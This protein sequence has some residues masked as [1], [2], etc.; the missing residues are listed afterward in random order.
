LAK[1]LG[2][3]QANRQKGKTD[4]IVDS[5]ATELKI[6]K[7]EITLVSYEKATVVILMYNHEL[8][9]VV[10]AQNLNLLGNVNVIEDGQCPYF[11]KSTVVV[12]LVSPSFS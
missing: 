12:C 2:K 4:V 5:R 7:F 10:D 11:L 3:I 8:I 9:V 6:A 1:A